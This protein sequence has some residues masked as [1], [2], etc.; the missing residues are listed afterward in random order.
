MNT[1]LENLQWRY[2]TK[3]FSN[4]KIPRDVLDRIIEAAR[5]SPSS[6]GIEPWH[7]IHVKDSEVR[8]RLKEVGYQQPKITDA[9]D[10][11]VIATKTNTD[12]LGDELIHRT[13][14]AQGVADVTELDGFKQMLNGSFANHEQIGNTTDWLKA[15]TYILLGFILFAAALEEVDAGPMEGFQP[16]AVDEILGLAPKGL[17]AT[18]MVALGYRSSDDGYED[19]EKVR[20]ST[21]DSI[22]TV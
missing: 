13:A 9:S 17:T 10:L 4:K 7:L 2:A 22:T 20:R 16:E 5:L 19:K 21:K 18:T 3:E 12:E 14:K 1:Y 15:Q 6:Y 11:L 8:A